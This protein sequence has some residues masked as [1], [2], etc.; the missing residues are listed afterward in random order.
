MTFSRRMIVPARLLAFSILLT[1]VAATGQEKAHLKLDSPFASFVEVGTP[2]FTQT[3]DARAFGEKPEPQNLTPR[4]IIIPAGNGYY[5]CFDPDL[6]RWSLFWRENEDGEYLTMD[7]MG[8]GSYRLPNRKSAPGQKELPRPLGLPLLAMPL[9]PGV[10]SGESPV[11]HDPR[12]RG[13]AE[14][15]ELG[16]GP[17][18]P[19]QGRF[20]GIRL[21]GE[22]VQLE[23]TIGN[24]AVRERLSSIK[25]KVIRLLEVGPR[26]EKIH[27]R[28]GP[29]GGDWLSLAPSSAASVHRITLSEAGQAAT[30]TEDTFEAAGAP[31]RRWPAPVKTGPPILP[32]KAAAWVFDD[33][34]LPVP[35]PWKRNVRLADIDYLAD[36]R[37]VLVTFDGDVWIVKGLE[38]AEGAEWSRFA[39]GLHDPQN[40]AIRDGEILVFDRNGIV[41]LVDTDGNGEAD[42]YENVSNIVAQSAETRQFPMDFVALPDGSFYLAKGGQIGSTIGKDNGTVLKVAPDGNSYEVVATGF[43]QPY[44]GYDRETGILTASDQQGNWKPATPIYRVE[45]GRYFGFQ[46][47]K[48][49]DKVVHPATIDAPEVWIPHFIN[50]SGAGQVW[51]RQSGSSPLQMGPLND[52]LVHIGYNRPEIFKVYL[53]PKSEQGAVMPLL[54]GFPSGILNGRVSPNDGHLYVTGFQI[55]GSSGSRIS[56]LYRV[57]P[58]DLNAWLP[59]EV[60]AEK[61][62]ILLTFDEALAPELVAELGRYSADRWNYKQTHEYGSGNYRLNGEPGQEALPVL[63][64]KLSSDGKSLFLGMGRMEPS[65]TLRLTYRL[66]APEVIQVENLYLTIQSLPSFDLTKL[67]F[68]DNE[69]DLTPRID[70]TGGAATVEPTAALGKEVVVRYGCVACHAT[71]DPDIPSPPVAAEGGAKVAVGPPWIGL[72]GASR[73]FSDGSEI[74]KIDE[75]YLRESILDPARRVMEGYEMERT[76]VGMP[77]YLGV[78]K[79]HEIDSVVLFIKGLKKK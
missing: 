77:S 79:D 41:R 75:A 65:H 43:R 67:G 30:A 22:G 61:R 3:V 14:E 2:Y 42:W 47:E 49:K 50:Q 9:L 34:P 35:N 25:G 68:A 57:R 54:S 51:V 15:G 40:L 31:S 29:G 24:T 73:V 23:Y 8:T 21:V 59:R 11:L 78:L 38:S 62:G 32:A 7:G 13:K 12:E 71:G 5:G 76:G 55:F 4:G 70:L 58:G 74:K 39:A 44:L 64:A 72:W 26:T 33:L 66:P 18:P 63:S 10:A 1:Y 45:T 56:G 17:I 60:R 53:D 46:P 16:L 28:F 37:A 20:S 19:Q 36:G 27:L 69:V 52:A 6:L 48:F